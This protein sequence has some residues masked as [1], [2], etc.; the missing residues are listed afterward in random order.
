VRAT[1][2]PDA[3]KNRAA[4]AG[5][6]AH[7]MAV[8]NQRWYRKNWRWLALVA[9]GVVG[10]TGLQVVSVLRPPV[11]DEAPITH[12]ASDVFNAPVGNDARSE[13]IARIADARMRSY[14][15]GLLHAPRSRRSGP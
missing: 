5:A 4:A 6:V 11:D 1:A 2:H 3:D 14:R 9:A 12:A 13:P 15:D 10:L 8:A 7:A